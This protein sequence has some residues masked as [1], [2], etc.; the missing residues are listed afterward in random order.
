MT[1][2]APLSSSGTRGPRRSV[3]EALWEAIHDA[4]TYNSQDVVPPL[5]VLWTDGDRQWPGAVDELRRQHPLLVLGDYDAD[6]EVGPAPWIRLRIR[7]MRQADPDTPV[8]VY[9]PG[10]ARRALTDAESLPEELQPLAALAVRGNVF[11]QQNSTD[12]TPYAFLVNQ[13]KGLGLDVVNDQAT[14]TALRQTLPVLLDISVDDLRGKRINS[15]ELHKLLVDDPV[16]NILRWL[17]KP[18]DFEVDARAK[19]IWDGFVALVKSEWKVSPTADGVLVGAE[20]LGSQA[21]RWAEVWERFLEA[22]QGYPGVVEALHRA[23]PATLPDP[24]VWPQDNDDAEQ[25]LRSA[26]VSTASQDAVSVRARLASLDRAHADRR[27]GVWAKLERVPM[28]E[29]VFRLTRLAALTQ[30]AP[31]GSSAASLAADYATSGWQA[32]DAFMGILAVLPPGD[33]AQPSLNTL[34]ETLYRPW[35]EAATTSFQA[36]W[37]AEPAWRGPAAGVDVDAPSGTCVMFVDGLRLDVAVNVAALLEEQGRAAVLD[38]GVAAVPTITSTGKPA[39]SPLAGQLQGGDGLVPRFDDGPSWTQDA[40]RKRLVP[41]GWTYVAQDETGDP[42]TRGWTE[43]G[44]IDALGHKVG[45]SLARHL[46]GESRSIANRVLELLS[47]GWKEVVIV[48]DHGWLLLP[49]RL[50]KHP[51]P[52]HLANEPKGRCAR[53]LAGAKPPEG[54]KALP[55]RF[56]ENVDIAFAPGIYAFQEGHTYAHGG[57]SLQE[58]IVP[59]LAVSSGIEPASVRSMTFDLHWVGLSLAVTLEGAPEGGRVDLRKNAADAG[60]SMASGGKVVRNGKAR[61]LASDEHGGSAAI[62]VVL[63]PDGEPLANKP[64]MIPEA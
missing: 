54:V 11:S 42:S 30:H 48:T 60:S 45:V 40:F 7:E 36:A 44:D 23:K 62:V 50:P 3:R 16:R 29:A 14:R 56:D 1:T 53:L 63:G 52:G 4:A 39:V 18:A 13:A 9:L 43:G 55:W 64:T 24:L 41:A 2:S 17:D 15:T 58:C 49:S 38:W 10:I 51:L 32:D 57:I 19:G 6:G 8:I 37:T 20:A 31:I 47:S 61:L 21:G 26:L 22:P 35:L 59:R 25:E 28:A 46:V 33:T 27:S 34:A 5:A 12:W